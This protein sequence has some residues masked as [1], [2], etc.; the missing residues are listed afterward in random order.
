MKELIE[1]YKRRLKTVNELLLKMKDSGSVNDI[2]KFERLNTKASEY[3]TFIAELEKV[4]NNPISAQEV[5]TV[6]TC[7]GDQPTE[8]FLDKEVAI[9]FAKAD[10]A[11]WKQSRRNIH[12]EMSEQ[13]FEDYYKDQFRSFQ[14]KV[15]DLEDAQFDLVNNVIT[16]NR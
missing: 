8:I 6:Q 2:K 15:Q 13:E 3:R 11:K 12:L 16:E 14:Y 7:Y 9:K 10:E 5:F 1:D 4:Y